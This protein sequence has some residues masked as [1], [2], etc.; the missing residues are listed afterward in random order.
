M[1]I[2]ELIP[3]YL[4]YLKTIGRSSF[5]IRATK[6]GL[7]TFA[8]FMEAEKVLHIEEITHEAMSAYQEELAFRISARGGLLAIRAQ[9]KLLSLAKGF[10]RYLKDQDYLITDP[11]AK[12]KLPKQPKPKKLSKKE[13]E[14]L[15]AEELMED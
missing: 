12:I 11:G 4:A 10:T 9:E 5:T 8:G 7:R 1:T 15:E 6:Y 3:V 2:K 14:R 13:L